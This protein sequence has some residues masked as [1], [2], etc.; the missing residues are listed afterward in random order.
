MNLKHPSFTRTHQEKKF[1]FKNIDYDI[2]ATRLDANRSFTIFNTGE[3]DGQ[4]IVA[5]DEN[6]IN[7]D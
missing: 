3:L 6:K 5:D 4:V 1:S 2:V 7:E